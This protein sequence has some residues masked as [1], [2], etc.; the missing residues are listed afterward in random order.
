MFAS[1]GGVDG[2]LDVWIWPYLRSR[3]DD[4]NDSADTFTIG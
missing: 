4:C 2:R 3:G 1:G